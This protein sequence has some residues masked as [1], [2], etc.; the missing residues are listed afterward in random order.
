MLHTSAVL[1]LL[2]QHRGLCCSQIG[3]LY[4]RERYRISCHSSTCRFLGGLP[5]RCH[6]GVLLQLSGNDALEARFA[7]LE[8]GFTG[9]ED[10]FQKMKNDM[11]A[12]GRQI[13]SKQTS[14]KPTTIYW[15]SD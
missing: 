3:G 7:L 14:V 6:V 10:D 9:V 15:T 12:K 11:A 2:A 8:G 1:S 4:A 13:G 5:V